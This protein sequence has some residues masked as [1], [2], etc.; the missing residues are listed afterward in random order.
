MKLLYVLD[1]N[2]TYENSK[3]FYITELATECV[4]KRMMPDFLSAKILK[5]NYQGNVVP[6]MG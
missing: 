4:A 6:P 5:E 2:N 1:E 3:Y